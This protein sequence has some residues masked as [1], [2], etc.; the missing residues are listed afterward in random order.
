MKMKK[1]VYMVAALMIA[2][3]SALAVDPP[4]MGW[5]SWNTYR[6]NINDSLIAGQADAMVKTGLASVGYS[7]IN[8]DDGYFGG[9]DG[10]GKL[11]FHPNRFPNGLKGLVDHIHGLG[12][13]AGIYSDAGRNTCGSYWDSD[14]LGVGV[15]LYGHDY[16]DANLFFNE[17]GFD[18]IK[19]DFCGG[20]A[21]Q[22]SEKLGLSERER[23]TEISKAIQSVGRP[24]RFNVCRWAYPG[25][26]VS[27]VASSWRMST[28]INPSW[29]SVQSIIGQNLYLSAF[30]GG[31]S[32]NDMDM[33]EVG[34]G[35]TDE[36]DKTHFGIWCIMS[37]PLLIGCDLNGISPTTLALLKNEELIALNQDKLGLQA[38]V[39]K[40]DGYES[41]VLVKDIETLHGK[42]RAVALYN[43]SD[44]K[45]TISVDFADV[46][47]SSP[48]AVRDLFEHTD[49]GKMTES[50]SIEVPAHGCRIYML[51]GKKRLERKTYE[52]ETAWLSAYQELKDHREVNA[53]IFERDK[54]CSGGMKV[55]WLGAS[56]ENYM[57]W[58][59]VHSQ[60]GGNYTMNISCLSPEDG[61]M[62]VLVNGVNAGV[63]KVDAALGVTV[64][65]VKVRLKKGS[66][67]VCLR[68][69][70]HRMPQI[71]KMELSR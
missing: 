21:K 22:N 32:F 61:E 65:H 52:A 13:K 2:A 8:I 39:A 63:V 41:Y 19:V 67:V 38:Y 4:T 10:N 47:L 7:Y 40:N 17:L 25:T 23:Y 35:M 58:R 56:P 24:V 59:D 42:K 64:V 37:S 71:D 36:E 68:N 16:D 12:L 50:L 69:D 62:T 1:N 26:W 30:A 46:E 66:N 51:E 6:V 49:L 70:S 55:S 14:T 9:R 27:D 11:I 20:D 60:K 33:L 43:P 29:R 5:S 53:P 28:D 31:G 3:S 15:G 45:R 54:S 18:F 57:E 44:S 34:R 48:V